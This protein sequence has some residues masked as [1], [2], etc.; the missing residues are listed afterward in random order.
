MLHPAPSVG[1]ISLSPPLSAKLFDCTI[2]KGPMSFPHDYP[3]DDV[4][5]GK[6]HELTLSTAA[7]F[8]IFFGLV[9]LCG[10]FF[11]FGYSLGSHKSAYSLPSESASTSTP[12]NFGAFKPAAGQ[13]VG[14]H[15][16]AVPATAPAVRQQPSTDE[17]PQP[18][19]EDAATAKSSPVVRVAP[20]ATLSRP[21]ATPAS[22]PAPVAAAPAPIAFQVQ[23][24]A[25]NINH[26]E[27]ANLLMNALKAKGYAISAHPGPD[28]FIHH[29]IGPFTN[30]AAAESMRQRLLTDGYTAYI[31]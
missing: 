29:L 10:I 24:A 17:P 11:G 13:P 31:K 27:D 12:A 2:A 18:P 22:T 16:D 4:L 6:E 15:L 20:A 9:I 26:P 1:C 28:N 14:S 23:V 25:I 7:I 3:H 5:G 19:T 8:G 21:I 30:R